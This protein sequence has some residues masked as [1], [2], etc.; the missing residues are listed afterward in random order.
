MK[1]T[2]S[3][4]GNTVMMETHNNNGK[5][6]ENITRKGAKKLFQEKVKRKDYLVYH[7]TKVS[8]L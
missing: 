4:D 1:E 7:Y 6:T 3:D 5:T 8:N 2:R